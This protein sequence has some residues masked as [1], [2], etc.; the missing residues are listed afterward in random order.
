MQI[1]PPVGKGPAAMQWRG[2]AVHVLAPYD[3]SRDQGSVEVEVRQGGGARTLYT[4]AVPNVLV[5]RAGAEGVEVRL[6]LPREGQAV[7][8]GTLVWATVHPCMRTNTCLV[9]PHTSTGRLMLSTHAAMSASRCIRSHRTASVGSIAFAVSTRSL[10][11]GSSWPPLSPPSPPPLACLPQTSATYAAPD[12]GIVGGP[13]HP[14][15]DGAISAG[16]NL[17]SRTP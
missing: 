7:H 6:G 10:P 13:L 12:V 15:L 17:F 9:F 14:Y 16:P 8:H 1:F 2:L 5:T 3:R 11:R 4:L